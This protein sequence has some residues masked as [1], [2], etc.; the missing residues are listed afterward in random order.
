MKTSNGDETHAAFGA[1]QETVE[2]QSEMTQQHIEREWLN[3]N[4]PLTAFK[5]S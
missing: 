5:L 2:E 1:E 4:F 3:V